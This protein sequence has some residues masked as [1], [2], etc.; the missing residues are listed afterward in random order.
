MGFTKEQRAAKAA[1]VAGTTPEN[2]ETEP[3]TEKSSVCEMPTDCLF[4]TK[5]EVYV[6]NVQIPGDSKIK[7]SPAASWRQRKNRNLILLE[8]KSGQGLSVAEVNAL[9]EKDLEIIEEG[10][11]P[12]RAPIT[13]AGKL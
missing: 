2:T 9:E 4:K 8:G 5:I 3:I 11:T 10:A 12:K 6:E 1:A 13:S 7:L